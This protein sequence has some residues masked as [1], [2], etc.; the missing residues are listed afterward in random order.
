MNVEF[1]RREEDLSTADPAL[2]P[3]LFIIKETVVKSTCMTKN[4]KASGPSG[5]VTDMLKA[6]SNI[7]SEL[8]ANLANS[9]I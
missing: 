5:V 4:G 7:C 6:S 1:P 2:G 8:I 9:I 3:P